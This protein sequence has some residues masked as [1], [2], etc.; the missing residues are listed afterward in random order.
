MRDGLGL[1]GGHVRQVLDDLLG[2]LGLARAGLAGA[3]DALVLAI[4][5]ERDDGL[6]IPDA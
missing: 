2:V 3:E 1:G 4:C 6:S 5:G